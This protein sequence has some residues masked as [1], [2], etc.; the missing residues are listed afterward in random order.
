MLIVTNVRGSDPDMF[1]LRNHEGKARDVI[2]ISKHITDFGKLITLGLDPLIYRLRW[3]NPD[4][5]DVWEFWW[6]TTPFTI[7]RVR[8]LSPEDSKELLEYKTTANLRNYESL[9]QGY[10]ASPSHLHRNRMI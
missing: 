10:A 3:L 7:E 1:L 4:R 2:D 9:P 6:G 5:A 8:E